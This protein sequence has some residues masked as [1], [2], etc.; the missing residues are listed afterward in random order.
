MDAFAVSLTVGIRLHH[1]HAGHTLRMAGTFGGFQF[2]MPV[3]GWALGTGARQYIENYDHW[4][5]FALLVFVGGNML[6]EAWANRGKR[7]EE[8]AY[9][10]P[11]HGK[12]LLL[13]GIATS[14]D[15]M[16]VGLSLALL[17][18]DVWF[19]AVVIGIVCFCLTAC[20]LHLGKLICRVPVLS[21]MGNKANAMGGLV[22]VAIGLKILHEH[23]ALG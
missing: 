9:S 20:G 17:K 11:T 22:L 10:D 12:S 18:I 19:P 2:L 16:A 7:A 21:G 13:L 5:A 1:V 14:L 3:I 23:G 15:A 8:C 4:L 6:R